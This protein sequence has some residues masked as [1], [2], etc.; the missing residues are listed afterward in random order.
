MEERINLGPSPRQISFPQQLHLSDYVDTLRRRKWIVVLFTLALLMLV[1]LYSSFTTPVYKASAQILL[2]SN[3]LAAIGSRDGSSS[4]P[5]AQQDFYMTQYNLL[6]SRSLAY[7]VINELGLGKEIQAGP[8]LVRKIESKLSP[9][10]ASFRELVQSPSKSLP[11]NVNQMDSVSTVSMDPIVVDWYLANL[12]ITPVRNTQLVTVS[13][14]G[15]SPELLPRIVTTHAKAFVETNSQTHKT[16][17]E[18]ASHWIE[19]QLQDQKKRLEESQRALYQ[20]KKKNSIISLEGREN[21]VSQKLIDLNSALTQARSE[22]LSKEA[23]YKQLENFSVN[24]ETFLALPEIQRNAVIQNLRAKLVAVRTQSLEMATKFGPKHPRMIELNSG[25]EQIE[26]D[27]TTEVA[28]LRTTI[29]ADMDR[30]M[31]VENAT[32][33][34]LESQKQQAIALNEKA[35]E[36]EIL[37]RQAESDQN[38]YEVLLKETKEISLATL[39]DPTISRIVDQAER[40]FFPVK[41]RILLYMMLAVVFGLFMGTGLAFFVEYMD[42]TLKFPNDISRRLEIQMVGML[43]YD[44][45]LKKRK[46]IP[47]LAETGHSAPENKSGNPYALWDISSQ[48]PTSLKLMDHNGR[49]QIVLVESAAMGEGK[50]TVLS[51]LAVDMASAGLRVLMIDCDLQRPTL[52]HLF[53]INNEGG[54]SEAFAKIMSCIPKAGNLENTSVDDLFLSD[55]PSKAERATERHKRGPDY[56]YLVSERPADSDSEQSQSSQ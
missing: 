26:R 6:Q 55:Q 17:A 24:K 13:F 8:P 36:Y 32:Q 15:S 40:P 23:A 56:R 46:L 11:E 25:I 42:N 21:I 41:P 1:I 49:G 38:L 50:T 28:Q 44:R 16:R 2:E 3:P 39:M 29:K 34:T 33:A 19:T 7:R 4:D 51:K 14:Y 9:F 35:I 43:P 5:R 20:Y 53:G 31:A 12:E 47:L 37:K 10:L 54:L 27:I 48:L 30:A 18:K 22:R 45:A 52:H